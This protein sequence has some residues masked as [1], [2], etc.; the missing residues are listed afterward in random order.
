M[1]TERAILELRKD[2]KYAELLRDS[3]LEANVLASAEKFLHS[4]EFGQVRVYLGSKLA[5]ATVLDVGAGNGI[6]SYAFAKAGA[7]K[8]YAVEP[9]L[10][11]V[12]GQGAIK[13]LAKVAAIDILG[14]DGASLPVSDGTVDVLYAR[15]VLHH[16]YDLPSALREFWRVL[17]PGGHLI[18]CRDHVVDDERQMQQFLQG[19]IVHQMVGGEHAHS[20]P[21]YTA[22]I[23]G[24]GF[25]IEHTLGPWDSVINS[26]P[27]VRSEEE[28]AQYPDKILRKR[29]G[30]FA[31]LVGPLPGIKQW[32]WR[33]WATEPRPGRL[34]SFLATKPMKCKLQNREYEMQKA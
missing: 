32:C 30:R 12:V 29:F 13:E 4:A 27:L 16:I 31:K 10:S 9:D 34:Y 33:R 21:A 28:L 24:A 1:S 14:G 22:A 3:Y 2:T 25:T 7:G 19:H 17:R 26:F 15:Q 20:L 11:A 5:G 23:H 8:V 18:A 6:A